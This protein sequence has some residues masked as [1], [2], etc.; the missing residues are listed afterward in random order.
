[1]IMGYDY[2]VIGSGV[3]GLVSTVILAKHGFKV[4]LIE[5]SDMVGPLLRGF[6]RKGIFFDTGLHHA[7]GFGEGGPVDVFSRYLGL[8]KRLRKVPSN[9]DSFDIVRFADPHFEFRFPSGYERL[10]ENLHD[11]FPRYARGG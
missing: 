2:V 11:V 6:Y 9:P 10:R 3:S 4:A 8:S 1:M 7:G 5:R